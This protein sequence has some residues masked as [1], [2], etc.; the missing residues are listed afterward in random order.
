MTTIDLAECHRAAMLAGSAR[1]LGLY[2]RVP[3]L[4]RKRGWP[5]D[6]DLIAVITAAVALKRIGGGRT[7]IKRP[8]GADGCQEMWSPKFPRLTASQIVDEL[9]LHELLEFG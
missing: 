6:G 4:L 2:L 3:Q 1:A 5:Q 9:D 7:V 8:P